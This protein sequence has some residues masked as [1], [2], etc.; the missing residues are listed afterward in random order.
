MRE[1]IPMGPEVTQFK[2][3]GKDPQKESVRKG[4]CRMCGYT[5]GHAPTCTYYTNQMRKDDEARG[6]VIT[7]KPLHVELMQRF[8]DLG[9]VTKESIDKLGVDALAKLDRLVEDFDRATQS[10][11]PREMA[12]LTQTFTENAMNIF[13]EAKKPKPRMPAGEA[14]APPQEQ[15]PMAKA[16]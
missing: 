2:A 4:E 13:I 10:Q 12:Q 1:G 9:T 11:S 7:V 3:K 6:D 16:A 14:Q 5:G 15:P 8:P